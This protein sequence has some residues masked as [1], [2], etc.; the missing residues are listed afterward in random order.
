MVREFDQKP[1]VSIILPV[2]N[3]GEI[4]NF[5]IASILCQTFRNFELIVIDDGSDYDTRKICDE[6]AHKDLRIRVYHKK[7]EGIC[8][9]RNCGLDLALGDYIAFCDHDDLLDVHML[10]ITVAAIKKYNVD[11][12][13]FATQ[14][15]DEKRDAVYFDSFIMNI[16]NNVEIYDK[17]KL[18]TF[19]IDLINKSLFNAIWNGLYRHS[20]ISEN[21]LKFDVSFRHGGE[22][23]DYNCRLY[24]K[25]SKI[26][27]LKDCLYVHFFRNS[28]ST[29]AKYYDDILNNFVTEPFLLKPLFNEQRDSIMSIGFSY[30]YANKIFCT[31]SYAQKMNKNKSDIILLLSRI[32]NFN[33]PLHYNIFNF[34]NYRYSLKSVF[35][36]ILYFLFCKKKYN[37]LYYFTKLFL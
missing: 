27:I 4:L 10:E 34:I 20:F 28:L 5:T 11:F 1:I 8:A 13:K 18:E 21:F 31:L 35:I 32:S 37:L 19:L 26:A 9:A 22:D 12:V 23:F 24:S 7:N 6:I 15:K 30:Y 3:T 36:F 33:L 16:S 29:S 14:I 2:Y 25:A 17:N